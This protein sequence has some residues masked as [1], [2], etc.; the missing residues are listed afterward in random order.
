MT[1][2]HALHMIVGLGLMTW[3]LWK[4]WEEHVQRRLLYAGRNVG[5]LLALCRY[6][7]DIPVSAALFARKTLYCT[8]ERVAPSRLC[9]IIT[10]ADQNNVG[11]TASNRDSHRD[12]R[13]LGDFGILVVGTVATYVALPILTAI[14]FL[15]P[16]PWLLC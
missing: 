4:A 8:T 5:T 9:R 10:K 13:V 14:F 3:L 2:L 16:I 11:R 7:M 12:T 15:V 1:G 6:R